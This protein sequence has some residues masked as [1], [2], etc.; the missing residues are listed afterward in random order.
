MRKCKAMNSLLLWS[1]GQLN[2]S[3]FHSDSSRLEIFQ[4]KKCITLIFPVKNCD[5]YKSV[6]GEV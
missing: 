2:E 6:E 4:H 5:N 1:F 3:V